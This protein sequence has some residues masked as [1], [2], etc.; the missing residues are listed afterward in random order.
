MIETG[1]KD[2]VAI[3]TGANNP[4]GIGAGIAK[5]FVE[6]GAK[7]LLHYFRVKTAIS[8]R[9]SVSEDISSPGE[10]FYYRQIAKSPDEVLQRICDSGGR[11]HAH[12]ADLSDP[13]AI[14][15]LFDE[16][17]KALGPVDIL[18]NNAAHWEADTFIPGDETLRNKMVEMWTARP[19]RMT[20]ES[21]D[22]NFFVNARAVALMMADFTVRHWRRKANWGRIINI[23]TAGAYCF[24]SE[25]SYGAS[26]LALEG[27]T[28]SAALELGQFGITVNAISL[29]PVQTGWITPKL[30][31][32]LLPSIPLGRVGTPADVANAVIFL[33]S[34]QAGWITGQKFFVGGGHGV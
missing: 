32:E 7:V 4:Y 10:A 13:A 14:P 8:S 3:V 31:K 2:R 5:A 23:S 1:L 30:E 27:Y 15:H 26:K 9:E 25:V 28:R 29:G 18:V 6:Q 24:P 11:A 21:F 16:A 17:E 20:A 12:E 19:A 22:R 34:E 33:S